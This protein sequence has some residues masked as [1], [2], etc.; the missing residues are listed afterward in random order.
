MQD[1][2]ANEPHEDDG[3]VRDARNNLKIG[4]IVPKLVV[5]HRTYHC[6]WQEA[7]QAISQQ[8]VSLLSYYVFNLLVSFSVFSNLIYKLH[9][10]LLLLILNR[11]CRY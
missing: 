3:L 7:Q 4:R 2:R 10:D 5:D 6:L 1:N 11:E 8:E 9:I